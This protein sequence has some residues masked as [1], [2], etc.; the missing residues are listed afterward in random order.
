MLSDLLI[1]L[2]WG[3]SLQEGRKRKIE[4]K[5]R[6]RGKNTENLL[7]KKKDTPENPQHVPKKQ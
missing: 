1:F 6:E 5:K 3:E 7:K 2:G 4:K